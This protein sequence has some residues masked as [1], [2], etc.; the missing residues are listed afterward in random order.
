MRY[1]I[2]QQA[3]AANEKETTLKVK[4]LLLPNAVTRYADKGPFHSKKEATDDEKLP[5][6]KSVA[7]GQRKKTKTCAQLSM[8]EKLTIAH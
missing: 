4:S 5:L 7:I 2:L 3:I 8:Q 1:K 6:I